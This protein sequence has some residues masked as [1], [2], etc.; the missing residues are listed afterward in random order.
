MKKKWA[1]MGYS[2]NRKDLL[3]Y[4]SNNLPYSKTLSDLLN[5]DL[6]KDPVEDKKFRY[7]KPLQTHIISENYEDLDFTQKDE[8]LKWAKENCKLCNY[9]AINEITN[10]DWFFNFKSQF[11][12]GASYTNEYNG[13]KV[14]EKLPIDELEECQKENELNYYGV[15]S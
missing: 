5:N 1:I 2:L 4:D 3:N 12:S 6:Y 14:K 11:Y 13:E 9:F 8:V 10:D 15:R 7:L